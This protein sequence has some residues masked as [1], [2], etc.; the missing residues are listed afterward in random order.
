[1]DDLGESHFSRDE[2]NRQMVLDCEY[3]KPLY[4][5]DYERKSQLQEGQNIL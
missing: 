1:M 5:F 2:A 4:E 3:W